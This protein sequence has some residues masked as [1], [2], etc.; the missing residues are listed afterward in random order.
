MCL[1]PVLYV[2]V[3]MSAMC[4]IHDMHAGRVV[5]ALCVIYRLMCCACR[6]CIFLY[7]VTK[8]V[9][10][11]NGR[12]SPWCTYAARI[13]YALPVQYTDPATLRYDIYPLLCPAISVRSALAPCMYSGLRIVSAVLHRIWRSTRII[14]GILP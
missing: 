10:I 7:C 11:W 14:S 1:P 9:R 2:I 6:M 12:M 8:L 13:V 5:C 3:W 4:A